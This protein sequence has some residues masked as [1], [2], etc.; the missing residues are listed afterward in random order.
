MI[1]NVAVALLCALATTTSYAET[2][3]GIGVTQGNYSVEDPDGETDSTTETSVFG[4]MTMPFNRNLPEWR[5]WFELG[6]QSFDLD[7]SQ[8][9][10][11]QSVTST[12]FEAVIQRGLKISTGF[13]PWL[14]AG[15]GAGLNDYTDRYTIDQDGYLKEHF[16]DR[17]ETNIYGILNAGC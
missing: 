12:S 10:V 11:G 1:R 5:Y 13:R 15:F 16:E 7:A 8:T 6:H 2:R 17:S 9:N 4:V 14:G 3:F